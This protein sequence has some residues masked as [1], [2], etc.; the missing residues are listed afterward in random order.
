MR[1]LGCG[2]GATI[3]GSPTAGTGNILLQ[4]FANDRSKIGQWVDHDGHQGP[5]FPMTGLSASYEGAPR[6]GSGV[7]LQKTWPQPY[8]WSAQLDSGATT[9]TPDAGF[10]PSCADRDEEEPADEEEAEDGEEDDEEEDLDDFDEEFDEDFDEDEDFDDLDE[11]EDFDDLD[12]EDDVDEDEDEDE[13]EDV[14]DE[15]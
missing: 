14:D 1:I 7:F 4:S 13:D 8:E 6:V 3:H 2:S 11:D 12:E 15:V 5:T 10:A 9:W